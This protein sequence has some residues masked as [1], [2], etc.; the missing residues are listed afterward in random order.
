MRS[1]QKIAEDFMDLYIGGELEQKINRLKL[2]LNKQR[3]DD[4]YTPNMTARIGEIYVSNGTPGDY[5]AALACRMASIDNFRE[6]YINLFSQ[7]KA[8]LDEYIDETGISRKELYSQPDLI[9]KVDGMIDYKKKVIEQDD[10]IDKRQQEYE[11][12]QELID[13]FLNR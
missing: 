6:R 11:E 4:D 13:F 12:T 7:I 9:K 1:E 8:C 2:K 10:F 3:P 5:V